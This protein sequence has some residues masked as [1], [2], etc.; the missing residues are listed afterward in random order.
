MLHFQ[1]GMNMKEICS[2]SFCKSGGYF[3]FLLC[4][5]ENRLRVLETRPVI[6]VHTVIVFICKE[7]EVLSIVTIGEGYCFHM[8]VF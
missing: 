2:W 5:I 3:W 8:T 4:L 1:I 7:H 6:D